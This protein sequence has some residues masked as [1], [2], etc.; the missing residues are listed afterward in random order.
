MIFTYRFLQRGFELRTH[1]KPEMMV[2]KLLSRPYTGQ[3]GTCV[4]GLF[5]G[6]FVDLLGRV[7]ALTFSCFSQGMGL[8]H[9][10]KS[11]CHSGIAEG[12]YIKYRSARLAERSAD[13]VVW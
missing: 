9:C 10:E 8:H 12:L 1:L 5:H 13:S 7:K 3:P 6:A 11:H 4:L 2:V